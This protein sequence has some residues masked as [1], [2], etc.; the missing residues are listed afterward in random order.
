MSLI[1]ESG[2]S[3]KRLDANR[4]RLLCGLL[5]GKELARGCAVG[6]VGYPQRK[7]SNFLTSD[8]G[9]RNQL[10]LLVKMMAIVTKR[11]AYCD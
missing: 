9:A 1:G 11:A 10:I 4:M 5:G 7:N 3:G 8:S 6:A 2:V